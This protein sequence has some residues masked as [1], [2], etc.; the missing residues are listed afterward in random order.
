MLNR[1]ALILSKDNELDFVYIDGC[2][3]YNAVVKDTTLY[4]Q[5]V[6]IGGLVGRANYAIDMPEYSDWRYIKN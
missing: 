5:R 4:R 2:Y 6:K 1:S 3:E